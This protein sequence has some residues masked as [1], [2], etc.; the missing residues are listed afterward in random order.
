MIMHPNAKPATYEMLDTFGIRVS[1][2]DIH[3]KTSVVTKLWHLNGTGISDETLPVV[4]EVN[5]LP[6]L[7][8]Q[9]TQVALLVPNVS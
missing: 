4:G 7:Q 5:C 6:H 1:F 9:Q 3:R 8:C 2:R